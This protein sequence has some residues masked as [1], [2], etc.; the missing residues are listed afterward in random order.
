VAVEPPV[1]RRPS[2]VAARPAASAAA[3]SVAAP[4]R[5]SKAV[6]A[7]GALEPPPWLDA[8]LDDGEGYAGVALDRAS[9]AL[10]V[11]EP[12]PPVPRAV[13]PPAAPFLPGAFGD[14]WAD[15]VKQ[16]SEAGSIGALVRELAMQA[17][18]IAIDE[19]VDP[20]RWQLRVEREMLRAP[21]NCDKLQAAL[22]QALQRPVRL[23]VEAGTAHDSPA[24]RD[25]I[26]RAQRQAEAEATIQ[27]DPLV[28]ALLAQYEGARIVPG[29]IKPH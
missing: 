3:V 27:S 16:L 23:S 24:R 1:S 18:C 26:E 9:S 14:R 4:P 2:E 25:A 28:R 22:A 10:V 29:S 21:A 7:K 8:P 11:G 19:S 12:A 6:V 20:V 13:V 17:E 15:T 5:A